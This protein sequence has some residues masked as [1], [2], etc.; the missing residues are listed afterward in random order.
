MYI[1]VIVQSHHSTFVSIF[2]LFFAVVNFIRS[3]ESASE[4]GDVLPLCASP[5]PCVEPPRASRFCSIV[6]VSYQKCRRFLRAVVSILKMIRL[7]GLCT[8]SQPADVVGDRL[9]LVFSWFYSFM[10]Y[11]GCLSNFW[12][13]CQ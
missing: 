8:C 10:V 12:E 6:S 1:Y 5:H 2:I 11:M 9:D 7:P 4:M 13:G 3:G